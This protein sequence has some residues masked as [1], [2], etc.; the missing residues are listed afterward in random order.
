MQSRASVCTGRDINMFCFCFRKNLS[1]GS[2]VLGDRCSVQKSAQES[3]A[4]ALA[5]GSVKI[6]NER[7]VASAV[8]VKI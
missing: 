1:Q 4:G 5:A 7:T 3:D 8:H 2:K 6:V